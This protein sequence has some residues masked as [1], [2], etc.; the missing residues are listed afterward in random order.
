MQVERSGRFL[1][2]EAIDH[3]KSTSRWIAQRRPLV[4]LQPLRLTAHIS[5]DSKM[6]D[7]SATYRVKP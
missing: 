3:T 2:E 1:H 4:D 7:K 6:H 5:M